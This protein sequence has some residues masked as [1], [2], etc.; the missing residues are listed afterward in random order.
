MQLS[1]QNF[2]TLM[3][4]MAASVQSAA[5]QLLDLTVGS[6]LRAIL[7]AN[8]SVAL[9]IQWLILLVLQTTR[10]ATSAGSDLDTWMADFALTRLP[11]ASATGIVTVT[12]FT[13]IGTAL[14]PVG[15]LVRTSD[16]TQTFSVASDAT[17]A[18]WN[19]VQNGYVM[20]ISAATMN[21]PVIATLPGS[22]GNVQAGSITLLA[23]AVPGIDAVTN[24]SAFS[25]GLDAETDA[26][27]RLRF[28]NYIDSRSRATAVA[29][30]Y[31]V[32]SI[33]QG[34]LY[35]IQ[36]NQDVHGNLS[37]GNFVVTV[38]DGS[39]YPS[40]S[41]LSTV[42]RAVDAVRPVGSTFTVQAPTVTIVGITLTLTVSGSVTSAQLA[43]PVSEALTLFINSL[44]IGASLPISR[45]SQLAYGVSSEVSNVT[46]VQ[47]NG[48][49]GDIAAVPNGVIK[50][51]LITVN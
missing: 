15:S 47:I 4:N 25:N 22:S 37:M 26:A 1:L 36:E 43:A 20:G 7:E 42:Q 19:A 11:A 2:S 49:T 29:V 51:G 13:V 28:Q 50:A 21:V 18:S 34:L 30:G 46:Q 14:V 45:V 32:N 39:G 27:F 33:Q 44:P 38:D 8:A 41:L 17:N 12:R 40:T 3:Q 16:G 6:T 10:A 48:A 24:P 31:A 23:S 35:T 9:W 5:T